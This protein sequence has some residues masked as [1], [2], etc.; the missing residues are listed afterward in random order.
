MGAASALALLGSRGRRSWCPCVGMSACMGAE[1]LVVVA[2]VVVVAVLVVAGENAL[3]SRDTDA[4][5]TPA[6]LP[7]TS[8]VLL[9]S[10]AWKEAE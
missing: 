8:A 4:T 10:V 7:T 2:V 5:S 6:A 1:S 3:G 9:P